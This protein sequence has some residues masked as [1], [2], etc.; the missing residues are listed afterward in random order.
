MFPFK[1]LYKENNANL[2]LCYLDLSLSGY[3]MICDKRPCMTRQKIEHHL[4]QILDFT[5]LDKKTNHQLFQHLKSAGG[6]TTPNVNQA[7][8]FFTLSFT[9]DQRHLWIRKNNKTEPISA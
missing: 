6:L 5:I 7:S 9:G 8:M 2:L 3:R 1:G 4:L